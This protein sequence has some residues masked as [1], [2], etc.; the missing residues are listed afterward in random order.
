MGRGGYSADMKQITL[1]LP[2]DLHA[3]LK[4][5][6]EHEYRS[7]HAQVLHIVQQAVP[8]PPDRP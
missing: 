7:L 1:R 4:E 8:A 2:D 3:R 5:L 6:A